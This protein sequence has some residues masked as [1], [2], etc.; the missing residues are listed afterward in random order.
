MSGQIVITYFRSSSDK[1]Y[2]QLFFQFSSFCGTYKNVT[3]LI[4]DIN[5]LKRRKPEFYVQ[6][7]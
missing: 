6:V 2:L 1:I 3:I 4:G 7:E 5:T